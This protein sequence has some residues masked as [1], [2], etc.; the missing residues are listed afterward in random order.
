MAKLSIRIDFETG[1]LG[2]GKVRL[3]ELVAEAG[4]IRR[5]A[6][7]M[8]MSY[9][10]GWLLLKALEETFGA[11]LVGTSTGGRT[12]GGARLTPLGKLVV[13]RYR[14]LE[15]LAA[16]AAARDMTAL[17]GRVRRPA[18]KSASKQLSPR[19]PLK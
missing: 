1:S 9:R 10:K 2:P 12:G 19:K 4:S 16:R 14:S 13:R 7:G 15:M 8:K 3:L 17:A 18:Q 11:P 6:A 5:A